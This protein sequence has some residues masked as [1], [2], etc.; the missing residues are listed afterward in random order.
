MVALV[1]CNNFYAS[2]ER[3]F[4]PGIRTSPVVVLSNNDGCVIARSE[5]AKALGIT[6]GA[7]AFLMEKELLANNVQ[8]FSSNYTLYGSI[9]DRVH[10]TISRFVRDMEKYS[11]DESFVDLDGFYDLNIYRY[12]KLIRA[13][14]L[15][16]VGIP[17]SIGIAPT[18]T[19]AKM[20][21]RY[22]KKERRQIGVHIL[23]TQQKIDAVLKYTKVED[24]WGIGRQFA[25]LLNSHG[26]VT[27]WD[28]VRMPEPWIRKHLSIVGLRLVTELK[29]VACAE[30]ETE[31]AI[32]KNIGIAKSFGT[33][34][35]RREDIGQAL[36]NYVTAAAEKLRAQ[37]SCCSRMQV[38]LQT[39]GFRTQDKQYYRSITINLPVATNFTPELLKYA[40]IALS[41]IFK[42]G[43]NFKKV[44]VMMEQLVPESQVQLGLYDQKDRDRH[45]KLMTAIDSINKIFNGKELVKYGRQ[46]SGRRYSLRRQRLS[47]CYTTRLTEVLVVR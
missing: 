14:V 16:N 29:G 32:R 15:R 21:N 26:V 9:S 47:P 41:R 38:F 23:D 20:A 39:N 8:V 17:V 30:L 35:S 2:A 10:A 37:N 43:Y 25:S 5:E 34:L 3:L 28:L 45:Q 42:G 4:C 12:C 44:G 18:R 19:L 6:M 24:V 33:L 31:P 7:P 36:A 11:I 27:A 46:G 40:D 22:A 13:T 1:D